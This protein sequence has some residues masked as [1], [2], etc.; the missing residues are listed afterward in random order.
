MAGSKGGEGYSREDTPGP[1]C[2]GRLGGQRSPLRP[3]SDLPGS[4]CHI[5]LVPYSR[6]PQMWLR[7]AVP[8]RWAV[9]LLAAD[10]FCHAAV[11]SIWDGNQH[12]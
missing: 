7:S 5:G 3:N 2:K 4:M 10:L 9:E 11:V 6:F 12:D 1:K 8:M